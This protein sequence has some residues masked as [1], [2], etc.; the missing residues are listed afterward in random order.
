MKIDI[1]FHHDDF[2]IQISQNF[3]TQGPIDS[4]SALVQVIAWL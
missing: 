3:V 4:T 1:L 2:F